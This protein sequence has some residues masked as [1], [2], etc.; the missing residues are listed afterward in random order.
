MSSFKSIRKV[1]LT[2]KTNN[3]AESPKC[4][5]TRNWKHY[6]RRTCTYIVRDTTNNSTIN[7]Q[8][9]IKNDGNLFVHLI[10]S[11]NQFKVFL[12]YVFK[13][14]YVWDRLHIRQLRHW[15][16][17]LLKTLNF[18]TEIPVINPDFLISVFSMYLW[19]GWFIIYCWFNRC[20]YW[21]I[22]NI[23]DKRDTQEREMCLIFTIK[24][25]KRAVRRWM[26]E[27]YQHRGQDLMVPEVRKLVF[28]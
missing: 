2:S 4:I 15:L 5:K 12:D 21:L 17:K 11:S 27:V 10:K 8:F 22:V 13:C 18:F 3:V 20:F 7:D 25:L 24:R 16:Q 14:I 19:C 9:L 6:S 23:F 1:N 26:H 28:N